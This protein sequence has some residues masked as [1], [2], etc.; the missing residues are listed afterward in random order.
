MVSQLKNYFSRRYLPR[1]M[2]FLFDLHVIWIALALA[3]ILRFNFDIAIA[4]EFLDYQEMV[5]A[6][7]VYATSFYIIK[8][9][10]GILRQSTTEDIVRILFALSIGSIVLFIISFLLRLNVTDSP[11]L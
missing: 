10:S 8:S 9:Y 1:W 3:Y 4:A 2:V 6:V 7:V 5:L 11:F